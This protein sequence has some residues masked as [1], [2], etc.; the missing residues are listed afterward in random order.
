M[1]VLDSLLGRLIHT[2]TLTVVDA[3]GIQRR[4]GSGDAPRVTISIKDRRT[5]LSLLMDPEFSLGQ[6][7]MDGRLT[8][9]EGDIYDFLALVLGNVRL[10]YSAGP[11]APFMARLRQ[12]ARR[13]T[14]YNPAG[15][16]KLNVAHHYDLSDD[17]FDLFL[18]GDR[19]YSCAYFPEL[20]ASIEQAQ[21]YKKRHIAAKLLL[22]P[23]LE[24]LD[25][26]S[27][28]GGLGLYLSDVSKA[29]VT[30][31]TLSE[32]QHRVSNERAKAAGVQAR[33]RFELRDYRQETRQFDRIVSVGMFEHVG[34]NHYDAYFRQVASLLK[35]DGVALI[36]SIG[37]SDGPGATNPWIRRYIFPGGYSP[38][39]SEVLPA[40][41]RAGLIVT[42]VEILRLHYAET[43]KRWRARFNENRAKVRALYD[44][45]FCRMWEFY[46]ASSEATFR[47][48]GH[49]VFQIQLAKSIDAVPI[50]RDYIHDAEQK[51]PLDMAPIRARE[52]AE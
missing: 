10:R 19:Q 50:T 13:V 4:Y 30:G 17:L 5:E 27:G 52:A 43:L 26:G 51:L 48:G 41:E 6:A 38:A 12:L 22:R 42:D 9:E 37:R 11:F 15:T 33:V 23:G 31:I 3:T 36:H 45:R 49:M 7:F 20:D 8:V 21:A 2:G 16:S 47:W 18:D 35:D 44:E 34:V 14:Q 1:Y 40:I 46:L 24:V 28:W 25:I 39:L 32:E 29:D